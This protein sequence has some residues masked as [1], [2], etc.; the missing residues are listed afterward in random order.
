MILHNKPY[1]SKSE[2]NAAKNVLKSKNLSLNFQT[3]LFEKELSKFLKISD[4]NVVVCSSGSAALYL[5][6]WA[7]DASNKNVAY[8]SY[9]CGA[10]RNAVNLI[11]AKHNILDIYS[12]NSP[13]LN[14]ETIQK[15]KSKIC[16]VPHMY[17][18]PIDLTGIKNKIIIE[19]CCHTIGAKI[20]NK[21]VGLVGDISILSFYST[22]L[23]TSGGH[24]GAVFSKNKILIR[25][26]KDYLDFDQRKDKIYRFNFKMTEI[27]AAI[28]R[29]QLKKLN[30]FLKR[31]EKI[32]KDY[33]KTGHKFLDIRE[34]N[35]KPVRYRAIILDERQRNLIEYLKNKK[36][37]SINP[38]ND[39]EILGDIKKSPNAFKF[40]KKTVSI[41]IYPFLEDDQYKYIS[42]TLREYFK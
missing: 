9:V 37:I 8:P 5:A 39:W 11:N 13:N 4:D 25:K 7:V 3:R 27:G 35:V 34:K 26:I 21:S 17:G 29:E 24:G 38:L 16:I 41:P 28:G 32:F 22:K 2:L 15:S 36:I 19:D 1:V 20:D 12:E 6:L 10:V 18:V 23:L 40:S 14:K 30:F 31:R 42:K 33:K